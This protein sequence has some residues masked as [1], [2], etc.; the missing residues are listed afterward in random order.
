MGFLAW[1]PLRVPSTVAV[2]FDAKEM[3]KL[4]RKNFMKFMNIKTYRFVTLLS[5]ASIASYSIASQEILLS[6]S[7]P[8]SISLSIPMDTTQAATTETGSPI[9]IDQGRKTFYKV[10][11]GGS[12]LLTATSGTLSALFASGA[13]DSVYGTEAAIGYG[14]FSGLSTLPIIYYSYKLCRLNNQR[15]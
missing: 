15:N 10:A 6:N 12:A 5:L 14:I 2:K 11:I 4:K 9:V 13:L 8:S 1:V 7:S 3:I